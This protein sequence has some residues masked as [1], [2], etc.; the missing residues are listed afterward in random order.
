[1]PAPTRFRDMTNVNFGTLN[2]SKNKHL[3]KYNL[4]TG[5]YN[6]ISIDSVL[7]S[8]EVLDNDLPDTFVSTVETQVSTSNLSFGGVDGGTF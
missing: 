8:P 7:V 3:V 4:S 5:E 6:L 2:G 1:M